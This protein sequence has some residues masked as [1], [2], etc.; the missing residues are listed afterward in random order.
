MEIDHEIISLVILLLPLIQGYKWK[1]VHIVMANPLVKLSQEKSVVRWTD[2]LNMT[3]AVDWDAKPQ[4]KQT[5][6]QIYIS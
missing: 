6:T 1:Y 2:C 3:I 5:N 4:T